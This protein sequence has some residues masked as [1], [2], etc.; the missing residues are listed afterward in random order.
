MNKSAFSISIMIIGLILVF[1]IFSIFGILYF[2]WGDAKAVQDGLST[3]GSIFGAIAT[4][5]AAYVA[6]HLYN[7]WREQLTS[8][9]QQELARNILFSINKIL[10]TLDDYGTFVLLHSGMGHEPEYLKEASRKATALINDYPELALN[11]KFNLVSYEETF[12]CG[13]AILTEEEIQKLTGW[14]YYGL[15]NIL[16]R[17]IEKEHLQ[18]PENFNIYLNNLKRDRKIFQ[19]L[20]KKINNEMIPKIN[21]KA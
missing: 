14:Y 16:R 12:L 20:R 8:T 21:I 18:K 6:V 3:T 4:L 17:I 10:T 5:G 2:Y 15:T 7:D 9:A 19:E 1:L 13:N 11:L